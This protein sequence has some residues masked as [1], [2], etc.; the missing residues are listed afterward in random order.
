MRIFPCCNNTEEAS[1]PYQ[2]GDAN[3]AAKPQFYA[4]E[5]A[6]DPDVQVALLSEKSGYWLLH[7]RHISIVCQIHLCMFY[8]HSGG[9]YWYSRCMKVVAQNKRARFDYEITETVEAGLMLTG[10]EVK[11]CRLGQINLMGSYVSFFSGKAVLKQAKISPYTYAG[12]MP[13][14][15]PGHDRPLLLKKSDIEKLEAQ[16][17]IKG[18]SILPLEV[19]AGRYIKLLI[20]I[21]KGRRRVDKRQKIKEREMGRRVREGREE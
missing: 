21:G 13:D 17:H 16:Q 1:L 8:R 19:R 12:P 14:Y 11:S 5:I 6:A 3:T 4:N 10:Q 7:T 2:Q 15:D 20:G 18:I 9:E